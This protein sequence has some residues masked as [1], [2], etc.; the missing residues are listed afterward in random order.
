MTN[1]EIENRIREAFTSSVP[2]VLERVLGECDDKEKAP[3]KTEEKKTKVFSIKKIISIAA[4]IAIVVTAAA[5]GF[6]TTADK[7]DTVISFDVNPSLELDINKKEKVIEA[8]ALNQDAEKVL[9]DMKLEGSDISV[10]VNAIIGSMLRNNYIDELSNSILISVDNKNEKRSED[11]KERLSK[12]VIDI[13]NTDDFEGA[14]ISQTIKEED[15]TSELAKNHGITKGKAQL[16]QQIIKADTEYKFADLASLSINELNLILSGTKNEEKVNSSGT[17]SEKQY[18]GKDKAKEIVLSQINETENDVSDYECE[19]GYKEGEMVYEIEFKTSVQKY[20]YDINAKSGEIIKSEDL[21]DNAN[22]QEVP[23]ENLSSNNQ[24][25]ESN[26]SESN[27]SN[28]SSKTEEN[29]KEYI[30]E[31]KAR[32]IA[33]SHAK[34]KE[35]DIIDYENPMKLIKDKLVYNIMFRFDIYEYKYQIDAVSGEI[36]ASNAENKYIG[37]EKAKQTALKRAGVTENDVKKYKCYFSKEVY[38]IDFYIGIVRY[39]IQVDGIMPEVTYSDP[40][41]PENSK[42]KWPIITE[43]DA[44]EIVN[45]NTDISQAVDFVCELTKNGVIP[46]YQITFKKSGSDFEGKYIM[47]CTYIINAYNGEEIGIQKDKKTVKEDTDE[48]VSQNEVS[49]ESL[50][51]QSDTEQ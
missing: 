42:V 24:T 39:R 28:N 45:Y 26:V 6:L 46:V 9:G 13:L 23:T 25:V 18:I 44:K 10:A 3:F 5:V 1:R 27:Q 47:D 29:A 15:E 49:N 50:E 16:I 2:D 31:Q 30:S 7:V 34:V 38:Y 20:K 12:E 32:E 8:K 51:I 21:Q 19:L 40:Q 43:Q 35:S 4:A 14:V 17:A 36:I 33:L 22:S 11:L 37:E 48:N 41:L